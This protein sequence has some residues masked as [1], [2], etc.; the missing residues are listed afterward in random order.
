MDM[1]IKGFQ[2]VHGRWYTYE[3][4]YGQ[5]GNGAQRAEEIHSRS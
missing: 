1:C 5:D 4:D 2:R 3:S